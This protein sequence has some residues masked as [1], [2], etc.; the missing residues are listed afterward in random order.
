MNF[1]NIN[2]IFP[3]FMILLIKRMVMDMS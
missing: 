3:F 2:P 1:R